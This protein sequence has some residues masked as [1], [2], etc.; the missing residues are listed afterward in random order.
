LASLRL[1]TLIEKV[2]ADKESNNNG[3]HESVHD[4]DDAIVEEHL[5]KALALFFSLILILT[6][7]TIESIRA[8][9][10]SISAD[11]SV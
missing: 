5:A 3:D 8:S 10:P 9:T 4:Q 1:V 2:S 7:A 6:V 11:A